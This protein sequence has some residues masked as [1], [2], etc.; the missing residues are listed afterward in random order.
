MPLGKVRDADGG[1]DFVDV[2]AAVAAGAKSVDAQIFGADVDFDLVVNFRNDEDGCE[3]SVAAGGLVERRDAHEAMDAA[4]A[5][6]HAVGVFAF[7]Q[8][9]GGFDARF[10]AGR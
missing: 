1:F 6:E 9:G 3:R 5:C 8:H 4:F 2:L 10:F 7:D